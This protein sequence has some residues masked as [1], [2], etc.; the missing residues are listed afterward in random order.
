ML[1]F[2]KHVIGLPKPGMET[3]TNVLEWRRLALFGSLVV[4]EQESD[5]DN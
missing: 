1:G 4:A 3:A 5:I 2:I